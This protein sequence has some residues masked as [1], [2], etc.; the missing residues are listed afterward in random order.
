MQRQIGNQFRCF[1]AGLV[2][3]ACLAILE[4]EQPQVCLAGERSSAF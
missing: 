4:D 1:W 2:E 3:C